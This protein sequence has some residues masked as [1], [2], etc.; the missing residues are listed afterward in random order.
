MIFVVARSDESGKRFLERN[1]SLVDLTRILIGQTSYFE[2]LTD[3]IQNCTSDYALVVHDDVF[4]P[5]N[6]PNLLQALLEKLSSHGNWGLVGNAGRSTLQCGLA[7]SSIIRYL[8]DSHGGPNYFGGILPCQTIDGNTMLL[9]VKSLREHSVTLP[10]FHGFHLYDIVLSIEVLSKGLSVLVAPELACFHASAGDQVAFDDSLMSDRF[11]SE[12]ASKV[13]NREIDSLNGVIDLDLY[14]DSFWNNDRTEIVYGSLRNFVAESKKR[15]LSIV[16]RSQF[17]RKSTLLR[18]LNSIRSF[19]GR[20]SYLNIEIVIVTG[21]KVIDRDA[22]GTDIKI[23]Q[24]D[25][26]KFVD[27]RFEL[28]QF[29]SKNLTSDYI[30]FVDDDD[31]L[32]PNAAEEVSLIVASARPDSTF[33][34]DS[35][36]FSEST[37]VDQNQWFLEP[38]S[39]KAGRRFEGHRFISCLSGHNWIPFCSAIFSRQVLASIPDS[40]IEK[41][42]YYEDFV[43][44]LLSIIDEQFHPVY[45]D[46]LVAGISVREAASNSGPNDRDH[47]NHSMAELTSHLMNDGIYAPLITLPTVVLNNSVRELERLKSEQEDTY[48]KLVS[49]TKELEGMASTW[50]WRSTRIL[51]ILRKISVGEIS[52][53]AL[54]KKLTRRA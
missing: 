18:T 5:E 22:L 43:A 38:T 23:L 19:A 4:F 30:W 24:V 45:K 49:V 16:V 1:P 15:S 32:F 54:L 51:R 7:S 17:K 40:I 48:E 46:L 47:W 36:H 21:T 52:V 35:Q 27:D 34:F 44:I 11:R 9:N 8:S 50:T 41:V 14:S 3:V 26:S 25:T 12:L 2:V 31:W 13:R 39:V 29:A 20:A 6:F 10:D 53:A 42:V 28:V 33:F 37:Q